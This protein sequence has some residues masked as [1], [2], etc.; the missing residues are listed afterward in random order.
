MILPGH[1][2]NGS[3]VRTVQQE[4]IVKLLDWLLLTSLLAF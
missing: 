4:L 3:T 1:E 2:Y